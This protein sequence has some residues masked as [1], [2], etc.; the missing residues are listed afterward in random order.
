MNDGTTIATVNQSQSVLLA[1]AAAAA[2]AA[3][4]EDED[5]YFDGAV[6]CSREDLSFTDGETCDAALVTYQRLTTD[7]VVH[8]PHLHTHTR[9]TPTYVHTSIHTHARTQA[10]MHTHRYPPTYV[11]TSIRM[12][13]HTRTHTSS[14]EKLVI[15]STLQ[16]TD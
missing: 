2:A 9:Y 16:S 1:A 5:S 4:C 3:A 15:I 12:H 7:H 13:A 10:R 8:A 14:P 11:H 6:H